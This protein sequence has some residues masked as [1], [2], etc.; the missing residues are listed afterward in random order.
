M[1][2]YKKCSGLHGEEYNSEKEL[3]M[4]YGV[5][6]KTY[7]YRKNTLNL[8][9]EECLYGNNV[10]YKC[11]G[12][13][14]K[15]YHSE[16]DMCE[17][18]GIKYN[19]YMN[20]KKKGTSQKE[21]LVDRSF[22]V[23]GLNGDVYMSVKDMCDSYD[24]SVELYY[25]RKKS[26]MPLEKCLYN[27]RLEYGRKVVIDGVLY[28]SINQALEKYEIKKDDYYK[29]KRDYPN[30]S[31]EKIF[32]VCKI[33]KIIKILKNFGNLSSDITCGG[34]QHDNDKD[35]DIV[36][37]NIKGNNSGICVVDPETGLEYKSIR[38]LIRKSGRNISPDLVC[39][40]LRKGYTLEDALKEES[41]KSVLYD[42]VRY[43]GIKE[44]LSEYNQVPCVYYKLKKDG[45]CEDACIHL[46]LDNKGRGKYKF[47]EV[48]GSVNTGSRYYWCKCSKCGNEECLNP[49]EMV[50]HTKICKNI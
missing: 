13:D 32:K 45:W 49:D 44:L 22:R 17:R 46:R 24:I 40:R 39:R 20:R 36:E 2:Y 1:G 34:E 12:P 6:Y 42:G 38:E 7:L 31:I 48:L 30:E 3:C 35:K 43:S 10:R 29:A 4:A 41:V 47:I 5:K 27:G 11:V 16:K 18:N 33:N 9:L 28:R 37:N 14:G 50:D 19:T 8:S 26:G 15:E 25:S 23:Y 21:S